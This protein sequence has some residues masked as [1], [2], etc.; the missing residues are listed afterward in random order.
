MLR[1]A[2]EPAVRR[3]DK[4]LVRYGPALENELQDLVLDTPFDARAVA[5]TVQRIA[6]STDERVAVFEGAK[7]DT[8]PEDDR[9]AHLIRN[10]LDDGIARRVG[11]KRQR[12]RSI[13]D[14]LLAIGQA[15][16][17][18]DI[19][20]V[21][22]RRAAD[23][24][25]DEQADRAAVVLIARIDLHLGIRHLNLLPRVIAQIV[26]DQLA[27]VRLLRQVFRNVEADAQGVGKL[28][29]EV[30]ELDSILTIPKHS[31][32]PPSVHTPAPPCRLRSPC[33]R[34]L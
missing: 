20:A 27:L 26:D 14:S 22:F 8:I 1:R 24:R 9:Q 16:F 6:G 2:D 18:R 4:P 5:D 11:T 34:C 23:D 10:V 3:E 13:T 7:F 12:E 30:W 19:L 32:A 21:V 28:Q 29:I 33:A 15:E 31:A 25:P 17:C